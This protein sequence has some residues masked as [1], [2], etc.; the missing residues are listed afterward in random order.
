M[1]HE[2][3][4]LIYYMKDNKVHSAKVL[5]RT[6]VENAHNDW[7]STNAQKD[8]F[9][10]FGAAGRYYATCHGIFTEDEVFASR[11]ELAKSL[12]FA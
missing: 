4:S 3:G 5:A 1:K 9:T 7:T 11:D 10:P 2:L 8:T 6:V 12:C